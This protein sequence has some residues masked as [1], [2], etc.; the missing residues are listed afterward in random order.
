MSKESYDVAIIGAGIIGIA[1][2]YYIKKLQPQLKVMLIEA[3]QPMAFTSAQ[4]GENY[5]NWWPH[6]VMTRFMDRSID[7]MEGI[8]AETDNRINLTRRGYALATRQSDPEQLLSELDFGYSTSEQGSIRLH[9]TNSS[10]TY[11]SPQQ[12]TWDN[13]PNGVDVIQDRAVIRREFPSYVR[14]IAT[15]VHVRRAGSVDSH[16]LGQHMLE[17]F[18][19][20]GG[21]R[22]TAHVSDIMISN[23]QA[24]NVFELHISESKSS[25]RALKIVNA[26][27][28]FINDVANMLG[29]NLP[30]Y[31]SLQQKIAFKDVRETIPRNMPFSIDLD[32]QC[33]DWD[34]SELALLKEDDQFSKFAEEMPGSIHC[35]P[36]GGDNSQWIK[37]GWAYNSEASVGG[38]NPVLDDEFPEI[39]LRGAARLNPALKDYYGNLP[40]NTRHYGGYY[41][42]TE[43]NWP[44]IGPMSE[45][46]TFLVGAMSGFG[47]MAACASGELCAQYVLNLPRPDYSYALSLERNKDN[48]LLTEIR[49]LSSRGIL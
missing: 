33:M 46:N 27:G 30:V 25:L 20:V 37:L 35:R 22:I 34:A 39:V 47:T 4:S 24:S 7:L 26:A 3:D 18:V 44:L 40:K 14:D 6:P 36:D 48:T 12:C 11:I 43:E 8:A 17:Y 1:T 2:A 31:N 16:Q 29:I 42:L 41:T 13:A 49:A 19:S 23:T 38:R 28:P 5:R 10:A 32:A 45:A 9:S 15:V 21:Q